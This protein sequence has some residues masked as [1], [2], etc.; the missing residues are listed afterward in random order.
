MVKINNDLHAFD[1]LNRM[2]ATTQPEH[3]AQSVRAL[4][5]LI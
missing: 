4:E 5:H 3:D 1:V 2:W